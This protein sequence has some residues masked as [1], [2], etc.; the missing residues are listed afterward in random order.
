M[1]GLWLLSLHMLGDYILQTDGMAANKLQSARVRTLHVLVY[2]CP[3][4]PLACLYSTTL[5]RAGLFT[6]LVF[7][8]HWVTDSRRWASDKVWPP[9][10]ILIDQS[11][12]LLSLALLG[13]LLLD[14]QVP[15]LPWA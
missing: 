2:T 7:I 14:R 8:T 3:F 13:T 6:A 4:A 11:L 10:P 5:A 12:H 15:R 9:K 1:L